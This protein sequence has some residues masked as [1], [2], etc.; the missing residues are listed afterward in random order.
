M[1]QEYFKDSGLKSESYTQE[2]YNLL[3]KMELKINRAW[4]GL[5]GFSVWAICTTI[6]V[7]GVLT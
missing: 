6:I 4:I 2:E 5:F 1:K 3:K 7:Y